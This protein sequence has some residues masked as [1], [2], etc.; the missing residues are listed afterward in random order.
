MVAIDFRVVG[1]PIGARHAVTAETDDRH[2]E[3]SVGEPVAF[4][5]R[6]P[7]LQA[8]LRAYQ[9]CTLTKGGSGVDATLLCALIHRGDPAGRQPPLLALRCGLR[10]AFGSSESRAATRPEYP[11]LARSSALSKHT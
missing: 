5:E 2:C 6:F 7:C 11:S 9:S 10:H 3:I 4:H 8:H 1:R